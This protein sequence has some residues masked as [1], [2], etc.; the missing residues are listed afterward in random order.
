[1]SMHCRNST[2][3]LDDGPANNNSSLVGSGLSVATAA[4]TGWARVLAKNPGSVS[5]PDGLL[6]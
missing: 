1:V 3:R 2:R 6:A 4:H 5:P